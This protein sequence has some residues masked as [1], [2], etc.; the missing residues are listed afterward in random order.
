M[1]NGASTA[2]GPSKYSLDE[3]LVHWSDAGELTPAK[4]VEIGQT[5]FDVT[6]PVET[7]WKK[8]VCRRA[9]EGRDFAKSS[10]AKSSS[11]NSAAASRTDEL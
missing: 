10:S 7:L 6:L 8:G 1:G 3:L 11:P 5:H 4:L 2:I 9:A